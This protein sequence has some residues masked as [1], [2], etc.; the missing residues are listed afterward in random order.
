MYKVFMYYTFHKTNFERG[1]KPD[2]DPIY[3]F[4]M[5]GNIYLLLKQDGH[6][7]PVLLQLLISTN[8]TNHILQF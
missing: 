8:N 3:F 4:F 7:W 5:R 2:F 1:I 6:A